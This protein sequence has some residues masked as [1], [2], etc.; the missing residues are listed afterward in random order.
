[1]NHRSDDL[2]PGLICGLVVI[3]CILIAR[4]FV[5]TAILDDFSYYK[6]AQ[7]FADTGHF[8]YNGWATAMLGWLIPWGA[9]FLKIFG[10]S[11]VAVRLSIYPLAFGCVVLFYLCAIRFGIRTFN[12]V[13]GSL[14]LGLS[15][16]FL[17]LASC[18]MTD[19][20]GLFVLLLCAYLC[21]RA[22][23]SSSATEAIVW[24]CIATATNVVGGTVR[25]I[26]WLGALAMVPSTGWLLR[27][28]RGILPVSIVLWIASVASIFLAIRWFNHQ[29]YS[30][31]EHVHVP[32][33][34][35]L[36][37]QLVRRF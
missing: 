4:P 9:L 29:P 3:V 31:P 21:Q 35:G 23:L 33:S 11:F 28:R 32:Q 6:T 36:L 30:V 24:L 18:F 2:R 1:M 17:P 15:P 26:A 37:N 16:L 25:Q 7:A 12:A 14:I 19:L 27:K 22:L 20:P 10:D 5:E 8:V 13:L 34:L